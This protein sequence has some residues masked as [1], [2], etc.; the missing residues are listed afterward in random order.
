E[1]SDVAREQRAQDQ[2]GGELTAR[3]EMTNKRPQFSLRAAGRDRDRRLLASLPR[4]APGAILLEPRAVD[5]KAGECLRQLRHQILPGRRRKI[6]ARQQSV[7]D[8]SALAET[9]DHAIHRQ[10]RDLGAVIFRQYLL[11]FMC[12]LP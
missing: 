7:T 11:I 5:D 6:V 12:F 8:G 2:P 1:Q 3:A 4:D 9:F 10:W